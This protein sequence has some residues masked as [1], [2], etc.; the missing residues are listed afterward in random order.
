MRTLERLFCDFMWIAWVGL[1]VGD[2]SAG[3]QQWPTKTGS[4]EACRRLVPDRT[5]L[6]GW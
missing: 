3:Q 5:I 2:R 4:G 6:P 1:F